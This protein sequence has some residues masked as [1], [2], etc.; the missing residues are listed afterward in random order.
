MAAM[1]PRTGRNFVTR[2]VLFL[3]HLLVFYNPQ[4]LL[5]SPPSA[6]QLDYILPPAADLNFHKGTTMERKS[7]TKPSFF[8]ILIHNDFTRSLKVPLAFGQKHKNILTEN[9]RLRIGSGE[10]WDVKVEQADD[11]HYYF[12]KGWE[13]FARDLKLER[14]DFIGFTFDDNSTFDVTAWGSD[15]CGKEYSFPHP[16]VVV[17]DDSSEDELLE[18]QE[19]ETN[20]INPKFAIV[21]QQHMQELCGGGWF[22]RSP[23]M[24]L[25]KNGFR[26]DFAKGWRDFRKA[27]GMRFYRTYLFEFIPWKGVIQV[28]EV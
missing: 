5:D 21:L 10:T 20:V 26:L 28:K 17:D 6:T 3:S 18:Q 23:N 16:Y 25:N 14:S 24:R 11:G 27:T 19:E 4:P 2:S 15:G 7:T 13:D 1:N 12:T 22:D 9:M 8:Q